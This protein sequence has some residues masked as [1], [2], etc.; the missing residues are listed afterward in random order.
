[1]ARIFYGGDMLNAITPET[2]MN[3]FCWH[4]I[5]AAMEKDMNSLNAAIKEV[6]HNVPDWEMR[7]LKKF[8]ELSD[9]DLIV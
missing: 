8:I 1:M 4:E 7:V 5:V 3:W 9:T 2:A 6:P